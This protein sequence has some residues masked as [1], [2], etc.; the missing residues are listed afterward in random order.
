MQRADDFNPLAFGEEQQPPAVDNDVLKDFPDWWGA[1]GPDS[2]PVHKSPVRMHGCGRHSCEVTRT[3]ETE[4]S[5]SRLAASSS[6]SWTSS[7]Q[8]QQQQPNDLLSAVSIETDDASRSSVKRRRTATAGFQPLARVK[9]NNVGGQEEDVRPWMVEIRDHDVVLGDTHEP[10]WGTKIY[11]EV[12]KPYA[13]KTLDNEQLKHVKTEFQRRLEK[14]LGHKLKGPPTFWVNKACTNKIKQSQVAGCLRNRPGI[15]YAYAK[16]HAIK[17]DIKNA[18]ARSRTR[19]TKVFTIKGSLATAIDKALQTV[20][21]WVADDVDKEL[22]AKNFRE[23]LKRLAPWHG[24]YIG[25]KADCEHRAMVEPE[26]KGTHMREA[27]IHE[28]HASH[29]ETA[30]VDMINQMGNLMVDAHRNATKRSSGGGTVRSSSGS[31][32]GSASYASSTIHNAGSYASS[33]DPL[34]ARSKPPLG[35]RSVPERATSTPRRGISARPRQPRRGRTDPDE[36]GNHTISSSTFSGGAHDVELDCATMEEDAHDRSVNMD[37]S[38][39]SVRK[40]MLTENLGQTFV[41]PSAATQEKSNKKKDLEVMFNTLR[42]GTGDDVP[43][44]VDQ[45]APDELSVLSMPDDVSVLLE[46]RELAIRRGI[47]QPAALPRPG[48][49][50]DRTKALLQQ[51]GSKGKNSEG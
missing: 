38:P 27:R 31:V 16:D 6:V 2:P 44:E 35:M 47:D 15:T 33:L 51:L 42:M 25:K 24:M 28:T 43:R 29:L 18:S 5:T 3:S 22:Y 20:Q 48:H 30:L 10:T 19:G 40:A 26:M 21:E 1:E 34:S 46:A 36:H 11:R 49:V 14:E 41:M 12:R 17:E 7:S 8:Q 32:D 37:L 4:T 13:K 50:A 9:E 45:E 23:D 39:I